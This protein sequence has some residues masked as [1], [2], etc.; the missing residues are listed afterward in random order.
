MTPDAPPVGVRPLAAADAPAYRALMLRA[1]A[2]ATDAFTSTPEER[3]AEPLAWWVRRLADPA[4]LSQAFGAFQG[5]VLVGTVAVEFNAKP[6]TRHK[7]LVIGMFV[8]GAARGT[9]CGRALL[10]AA[11]DHARA[12]PGTAVLTLTV[13]QG[14]GPAVHL[15]EAG[16]FEP[17]GV[18]PMAILTPTGYRAKVHMWLDLARPPPAA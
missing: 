9:G 6:K 10:Q 18:E 16:G 3:A 13:T 1:Y 7:G 14:N 2:Q 4:G 15:Y 5:T 12:R 11:V 8:D 17:F